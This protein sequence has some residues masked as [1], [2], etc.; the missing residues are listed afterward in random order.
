M[1]CYA[2]D[3]FELR[4]VAFVALHVMHFF[5]P[6]LF[7]LSGYLMMTNVHGA[8][9]SKIKRRFRRLIVPA[10]IWNVLY[11]VAYLLLSRVTAH[12]AEEVAVM[13][14]NTLEGWLRQAFLFDLCDGPLWY[15]RAVFVYALATPLLNRLFRVV[16]SRALVAMTVLFVAVSELAGCSV[17][18]FPSYSIA[19]FVLGA[20]L[21]YD[22]QDIST[23]F[24]ARRRLFA[25]LAVA[26]AIVQFALSF[27]NYPYIDRNGLC[28]LFGGPL[29]WC[30]SDWIVRMLDRPVVRTYL[31]PA[32]FFMYVGHFIVD[33]TIF[34]ALGASLPRFP[35]SMT[36]VM[37]V[38]VVMTVLVMA[39]LWRMLN[40]LVPGLLR[41]LDGRL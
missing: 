20:R 28:Q 33:V 2:A 17:R 23:F 19:C 15:I 37:V 9:G 10:V 6:A 41:V 30:F 39:A 11:V 16:S 40:R 1:Y 12:V 27:Q 34:H 25:S 32:A 31:L 4:A 36:L 13:Q 35:G 22:G 7:L 18:G 21:A 29:L 3:S 26:A 14:L 24:V 8:F 38:S 5:M